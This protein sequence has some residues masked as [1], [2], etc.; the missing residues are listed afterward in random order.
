DPD[1][2]RQQVERL[3]RFK[4]DRDQALVE[5]RLEEVRE[6]ARG[7]GNLLPVLKDALR[8]RCTLGEACGAMADVFGRYTPTF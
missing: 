2:E 5:R 8:D 1:S 4:A 7:T 3:A 6:A